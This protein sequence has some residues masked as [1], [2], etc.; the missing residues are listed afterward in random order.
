MHERSERASDAELTY[1]AARD[2][3]LEMWQRSVELARDAGRGAA[4]YDGS[5]LDDVAYALD[6][7]T[8]AG[9]LLWLDIAARELRD[10]WD[11]DATRRMLAA[12]APT[13]TDDDD[14]ETMS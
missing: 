3:L 13:E 14:E 2:K 12:S 6:N 11:E 1:E 7:V 5:L 9:T 4:V 8:T 10:V